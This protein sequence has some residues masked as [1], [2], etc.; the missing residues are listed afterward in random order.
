MPH[1]LN[2]SSV[3]FLRKT[4]TVNIN[5]RMSPEELNRFSFI[6]D[7]FDKQSTKG[8]L[9]S[10]NSISD[11]KN[12]LL[13][14]NNRIETSLNRNT[15]NTPKNLKRFNFLKNTTENAN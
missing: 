1:N 6:A 4:L 10:S 13:K 3:D 15:V 11:Q 8:D 9:V 2:Q 7:K 12:F 14:S 5:E